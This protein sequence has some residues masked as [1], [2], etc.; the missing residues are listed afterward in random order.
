[1]AL[2]SLIALKI[3]SF[4]NPKVILMSLSV[5]PNAVKQGN[6][7][8][9]EMA[10]ITTVHTATCHWQHALIVAKMSKYP[11]NLALVDRFTAR[12]A[13]INTLDW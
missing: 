4:T 9:T 8:N 5:A 13:T 3:K 10:A 11:L 1:V 2:L 6:Q 7:Y 12:V